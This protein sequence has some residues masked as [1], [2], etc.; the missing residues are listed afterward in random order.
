MRYDLSTA[1]YFRRHAKIV[2]SVMYDASWEARKAK[3]QL[4]PRLFRAFLREPY[5]N[6]SADTGG[7]AVYQDVLPAN[8]DMWSPV[9]NAPTVTKHSPQ[10]S[11]RRLEAANQPC[12]CREKSLFFLAEAKANDA[13][14]LAGSEKKLEPGTQATPIFSIKCCVN[15]MSLGKPNFEISHST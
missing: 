9:V 8:R 12:A 5:R 13:G 6:G 15:A 3:M 2:W 14:A 1:S 7:T 4:D 10:P 11:A